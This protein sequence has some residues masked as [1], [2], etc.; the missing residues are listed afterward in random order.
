M[1]EEAEYYVS[2]VFGHHVEQKGFGI[3]FELTKT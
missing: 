1:E 3:D 2:D